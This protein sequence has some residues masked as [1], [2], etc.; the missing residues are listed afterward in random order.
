[1]FWELGILPGEMR[2]TSVQIGSPGALGTALRGALSREAPS[3]P[4]GFPFSVE[5]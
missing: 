3:F 4:Q 5:L 2:E 1:M